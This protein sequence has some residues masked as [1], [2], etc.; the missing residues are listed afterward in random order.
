M[1]RV[2]D[3]HK[4]FGSQPV[5]KGV[6]LNI[7]GGKITT[8]VGTSGCG[9]TVL[10]KHLNAL[11][12]PDRGEVFVDSVDINPQFTALAEKK[13]TA[14]GISNVNL[15]TGDAS[16]GWDQKRFYDVIAITGSMPAIPETY[17]HSL[18]EGGRL[19]VITG[20]PP[21]MTAQLVTRVAKTEWTTEDLFETS[22]DPLIHAKAAAHFVF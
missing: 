1:I 9:K 18:K 21:V 19:F 17:K 14:L 2:V 5:L 10:L 8:I 20:E 3:L 7:V 13:L 11:L 12:L 16:Q 15:S 6:N 22:I 4:S